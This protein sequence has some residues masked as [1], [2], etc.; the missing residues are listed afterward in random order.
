[1]GDL[2]DAEQGVCPGRRRLLGPP[3]VRRGQAQAAD[4]LLKTGLVTQAVQV[5]VAEEVVD[6][7]IAE[8]DGLLQG[9]E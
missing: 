6:V 2:L 5:R 1:M 3:L 8:S 4:Q 7:V 9:F